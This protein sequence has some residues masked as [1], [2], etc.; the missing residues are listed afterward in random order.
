MK[1]AILVSHPIQYQVPLFRK[2]AQEP[3]VDLTVFFCWTFGAIKTHDTEFGLD[4]EWDIPLLGGYAHRFLENISPAP[5]SGFWG[6]INPS[7][8]TALRNGK[9]DGVLVYG[10]NA[11]TNWLVFLAA[12]LLGIP[13]LLQGET[14]LNQESS[15]GMV[16]W[17]I[18]KM[19]LRWLF[20][21]VSAFLYIGAENKKFYESFGVSQKKLHFAPYAVDNDRYS[22]AAKELTD[23]KLSLQREEKISPGLPI[24]LFAGK[25]IEKKRPLDVLRA[26]ELVRAHGVRAALVF[27]GDG[28]LRAVLEEYTKIHKIPD[29]YFVGFKNQTELPR[30]YAMAEVFVLSSGVGETWGLVVNEAMCFGLPV[31][32]SDVV[33]C[34]PDLVREGENGFRVPCGD[35]EVFAMRL[36]ELLLDPRRCKRFGARSKIIVSGYSYDESIRGFLKA[37]M[38]LQHG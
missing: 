27:V 18:R 23:K 9:Y 21:R 14:P 16:R 29:V 31:V 2:L 25:L 6:Q 15:R 28:A 30:Y 26:F 36:E 17:M 37:I 11:V 33:G 19:A 7:V 34:G 1:L 35:V 32:I 13:I 8:V 10:W 22:R 3:D 24:V 4:I 38:S 12:P 5:S 20:Q